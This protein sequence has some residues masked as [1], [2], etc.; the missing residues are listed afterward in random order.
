MKPWTRTDDG[1][2]V[3]R[4]G[5]RTIVHKKY[6]MNSG[7]TM[8]ADIMDPEHNQAAGV[9][10]L[11]ADN[12]VIIARQFRCGPDRLMDEL[13]GGAVDDGETPEQAARRE[14]AEEVGY[15]ADNF[16]L[17][18]TSFGNAWSHTVHYYF[19][20]LN[21]RK[22]SEQVINQDTDEEVEVV[23][24]SIE[25]FIENARKAKMND[26]MAVFLAYDRLKE[27]GDTKL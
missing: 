27:I 18:G 12:Q 21:C 24:I 25:Q 5:F 22:I 20:A 11:T 7:S 8:V 14:L 9:I 1:T 19:L 13:P 16:E 17:Q 15:E 3:T 23:T 2:N 10:A 26:G 6:V 4:A